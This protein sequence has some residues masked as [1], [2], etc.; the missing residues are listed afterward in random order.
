MGRVICQ[1]KKTGQVKYRGKPT[2]EWYKDG[3][4]QYYCYGYRDAMT[5]EPLEVCK[6]CADFVDRA[7]EDLQRFKG[8]RAGMTVKEIIDKLSEY[9]SEAKIN[10]IVDGF[11]R[12]FKICFGYSEGIVKTNCETVDLM[13]G[14]I[15]EA[16]EQE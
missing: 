2:I 5:E 14:D 12:P 16:G 8:R 11:E 6:N 15:G 1:A 7:E 3:K 13:V 4:P 9:N 10:V